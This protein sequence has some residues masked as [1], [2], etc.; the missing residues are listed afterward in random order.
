MKL[1][2][3]LK[4]KNIVKIAISLLI[5]IFLLKFVDFQLFFQ[6]I[7]N[8]N[9]LILFALALIPFGILL[10]AWRWMIILNK[11]KK[12]I[13]IKDSCYLNLAGMALNIF[14]PGSSG[15]IA[16]SYYGYKW[17]G[18]KEE[19]LSSSILDKIMALFSLFILGSI[20]AFVIKLYF[21]S[22]FSVIVTALLYL[23][24]FY[25]KIVPWNLLNKVFSLFIKVNLDEKKLASSFTV[26]NK[27]KLKVLLISLFA[28][29]ML[30]FQFYLICLS[31]SAEINFI[32][33]LAVAPLMN[34]AVLIP[35]TINGLGS[36]EAVTMYLFSL[37]NISPT[38]AILVSLTSQILYT[39]IPGIFGFIILLKK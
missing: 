7:K 15:D 25:P 23:I 31:F 14:L 10:R 37:I 1:K 35:F 29:I 17:H 36:L 3:A 4:N 13:S 6:S 39:V 16:K 34:I 24:I 20:T 32:Y 26:S 8:I 30:Y 18:F 27:I 22:I 19:M 21:L 9:Y 38:L 12:L 2:K 28:W 33:I 11:D 5:I